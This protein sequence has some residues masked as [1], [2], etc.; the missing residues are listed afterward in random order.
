MNN[1]RSFG[2]WSVHVPWKKNS[3]RLT[4]R[5]KCETTGM[6][7]LPRMSSGITKFADAPR[8]NHPW[9][10]SA[11]AATRF[12]LFSGE[13]AANLIQDYFLPPLC[14]HIRR[15]INC[16][17]FCFS[18]LSAADR[19]PLLT[20]RAPLGPRT[21]QIWSETTVWY[22]V[23][24]WA[25]SRASHLD[26][27]SGF[28]SVN[29]IWNHYTRKVTTFSYDVIRICNVVYFCKSNRLLREM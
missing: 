23:S 13:Y 7:I 19:Q 3:S 6:S 27:P 22:V 5:S 1:R 24:A 28:L 10:I 2:K 16:S 18:Y 4:I 20:R 29:F 8:E 14:L 21:G 12:R 26:L 11:A 15:S 25:Y 9:L 17:D